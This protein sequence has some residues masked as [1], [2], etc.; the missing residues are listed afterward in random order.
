M[1][2][3]TRIKECL[4]CGATFET[5]RWNKRFCSKDCQ[6]EYTNRK[7]R[8]SRHKILRDCGI[9]GKEFAVQ[10]PAQRYCSKRCAEVA[11][12]RANERSRDKS[13]TPNPEEPPVKSGEIDPKWLRGRSFESNLQFGGDR[14]GPC[15]VSH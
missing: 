7:K 3:K 15:T 14:L 5:F 6:R 10:S 9:C 8:E 11:K 2:E 4:E 1:T 12:L 13:K